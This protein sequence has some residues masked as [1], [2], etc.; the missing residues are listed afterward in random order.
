MKDRMK[1]WRCCMMM[2]QFER[3]PFEGMEGFRI[4]H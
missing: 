2:K 1:H 4:Y 3:A